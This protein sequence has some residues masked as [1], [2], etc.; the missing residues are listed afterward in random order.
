MYIFIS[1]HFDDAVGS[2]GG[3]INRLVESD[4]ECCIMTIMTAVPWGLPQSAIY[5][6]RRHLENNRAARILGCSVKNA[7]FLDA[8]YRK[9]MR[10]SVK[11]SKKHLFTAEIT[12]H[13]L[14]NEIRDYISAHTKPEDILIAPAGLGNHIDHRIVNLAVQNIDRQVYFYE[15]FFYDRNNKNSLLTENYEY[16][17]LDFHEIEEKIHAMMQY[18]K[19]LRKLFK[20]KWEKKM[21]NYFEI[22]RIHQGK[23]YERF[24]NTRFLR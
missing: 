19:T 21:K 10:K 11:R 1:P 3:I 23:P 5:V 14:V 15:E 16:V 9:E 20:R 2:A 7:S 18:K 12:E 6:L 22:E 24:N 17:S 13:D 4:K 8:P